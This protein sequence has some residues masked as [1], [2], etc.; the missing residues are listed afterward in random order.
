MDAQEELAVFSKTA[1]E[2]P[3][4]SLDSRWYELPELSAARVRYIRAHVDLFTARLPW[5]PRWRL[6]ARA[7]LRRL[8]G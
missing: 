7:A 3:W 1:M 4:A 5:R 8:R 2:S 6:A